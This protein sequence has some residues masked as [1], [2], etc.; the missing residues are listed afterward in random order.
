M[1]M[2]ACVALLAVAWIAGLIWV[3]MGGQAS[4]V[5]PSWA[6]VTGELG[7]A[8]ASGRYVADW[9]ELELNVDGTYR[10]SS[11]NDERGGAVESAGR[12][13]PVRS[14]DQSR[15][16]LNFEP[17]PDLLNLGGANVRAVEVWF[18]EAFW[19]VRLAAGLGG[20]ASRY[21]YKLQE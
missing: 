13:T 17:I 6:P 8:S 7:M 19:H 10:Y 18:E 14:N 1:W 4:M 16:T 11:K 21:L 12:W 15:V 5:I 2:Q 20:S 9:D 3:L